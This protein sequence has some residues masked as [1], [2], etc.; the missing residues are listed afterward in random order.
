MAI[1][2]ER[3][4]IFAKARFAASDSLR[5]TELVHEAYLRIADRE[6]EWEN[7]AHFFGAVR[8]AMRNAIVEHLRQKDSL[9]RGGGV[10]RRTASCLDLQGNTV[11]PQIVALNDA[12]YEL[13]VNDPRAA[14][15]VTLRFFACMSEAE[16]AE[17]LQLSER[18]V[19]REWVY[20]KAW[21]QNELG[22]SNP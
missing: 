17:E 5:G 9:K 13:G 22:E 14:E 10:R 4:R 2:Y 3:L 11:L 1:L 6:R 21:L 7:Q 16:I 18:T 8:N 19:R 12:L 15:V 20:A